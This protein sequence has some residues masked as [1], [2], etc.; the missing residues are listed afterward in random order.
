SWIVLIHIEVEAD[1]RIT[2]L[3]PRMY[4]YY[5][6]LRDRY[7]RPVWSLALYLHVGLDGVGWDVYEEYLWE[8][9]VL[10]FEY[11]YVGLPRLDA[12]HYQN[13]ESILGVALA[14][15]MQVPKERRV[16]LIM[17]GLQRVAGSGENSARKHLLAG[18]LLKYRDFDESQEREFRRLLE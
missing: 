9:C 15:M 16:E 17:Q 3:R 14:A 18:F 2:R 8:R 13:G 11:P 6:G 4:D 7:Q 5:K 1:D 12:E 10:H